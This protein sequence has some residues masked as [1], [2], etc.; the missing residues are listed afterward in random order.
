MASQHT[1]ID[2][3]TGIDM[4][5]IEIPDPAT[6]FHPKPPGGAPITN[7]YR[8]QMPKSLMRRPAFG[9]TGRPYKV[10]INSHVVEQWPTRDIF[11]YDVSARSPLFGHSHAF[12][13]PL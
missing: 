7:P 11:Q 5:G 13:N 10:A 1:G 8:E 6:D 12:T 3:R 2:P 4:T 9:K